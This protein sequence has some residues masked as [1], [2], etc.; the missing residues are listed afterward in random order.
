[1]DEL[2]DIDETLP[3]TGSRAKG[4]VIGLGLHPPHPA[5]PRLRQR[6][7]QGKLFTASPEHAGLTGAANL[8][9]Q[10][11]NIRLMHDVD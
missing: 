1:V 9:R 4:R 11:E 8:L 6:R 3:A 2:I 5:L 7:D 10:L